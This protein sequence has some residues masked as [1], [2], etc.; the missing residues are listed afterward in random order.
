MIDEQMN[1]QLKKAAKPKY[2]TTEEI[3]ATNQEANPV[4]EPYSDPETARTIEQNHSFNADEDRPEFT[5]EVN[6]DPYIK[7]ERYQ[8]DEPI[9]PGGPL[10]SQVRSWYKTAQ[11]QGPGHNVYITPFSKELIVIWR[12]INRAEYKEIASTQNTDPLQREEMICEQCVLWPQPF[13]YTMQAKGLAGVPSLIASH[14]MIAS[15]FDRSVGF[16][17]MF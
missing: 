14:I 6:M 16:Q 1:E 5:R 11:Q 3:K 4:E 15:G 12:T 13:T 7:A 9:F 17:P 10:Y 2:R 8:D